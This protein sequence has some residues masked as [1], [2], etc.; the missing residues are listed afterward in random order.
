MRLLLILLLTLELTS[1]YSLTHI[2]QF[3]TEANETLARG[4]QLK[5]NFYDVCQQRQRIQLIQDSKLTRS[6]RE[7]CELQ[8]QADSTATQIL[9]ALS[10]YLIGLHQLTASGRS[11]YS[12][13]PLGD[14][15]Q[16]HPWL[17]EQADVVSAYQQLA[18]LSLTGLTERSR[19]K[20]A[21]ELIAQ[22]NPAVQT[23]LEAYQFVLDDLLIESIQRQQ[24]MHYLYSRELL[25]SAQSF[26]EKKLLIEEFMDQQ[27]RYDEQKQHLQRFADALG[28]IQQGHEELYQQRNSLQQQAAIEA[29]YYYSNQLQQMELLSK[30]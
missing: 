2:Q 14:A 3:T 20:K 13:A 8:Q 10:R 28:T 9:E 6:F 27:I 23:L 12:L 29:L 22:A 25:D 11:G 4:A 15:L 5:P 30:F 17:E 16:A 26:V 1:C 18:Q 7:G 24:D 21:E 19:R